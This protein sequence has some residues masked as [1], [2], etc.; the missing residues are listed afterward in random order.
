MHLIDLKHVWMLY[1]KVLLEIKQKN[2]L[3]FD[4]KI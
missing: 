2:Y 1:L 3:A 4:I